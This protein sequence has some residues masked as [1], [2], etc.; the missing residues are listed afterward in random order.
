MSDTLLYGNLIRSVSFDEAEVLTNIVNLHVKDGFQLDPC[1]SKGS[2]YKRSGI[3][4]PEYK[5]DIDPKAGV[6]KAD[7]RDLPFADDSMGN[8]MFDPPFI[9]GGSNGKNKGKIGSR[10]GSFSTMEELLNWY[11][12]CFLEFSRIQKKRS[13]LV[14]KCQDVISGRRQYWT[15]CDVLRMAESCGYRGI[16]L[17]ILCAKNRLMSGRQKQQDHARKFHC[18]FWV[19]LKW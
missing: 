13:W 15:H 2:F 8:I 11:G 17:F 14:V 18:Y 6:E 19:F 4:V 12:Q 9:A 5:F 10:F 16:D 3:K 7:A 1:F